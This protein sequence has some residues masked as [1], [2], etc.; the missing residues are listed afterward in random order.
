MLEGK[1]NKEKHI[2]C[3]IPYSLFYFRFPTLLEMC[4]AKYGHLYL[5]NEPIM[6]Y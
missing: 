6:S 1:F 3:F 4:W 2:P 5:F